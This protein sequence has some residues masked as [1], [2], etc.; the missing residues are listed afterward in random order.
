MSGNLVRFH[1]WYLSDSE[2]SE[3][4]LNQ[5]GKAEEGLTERLVSRMEDTFEPVQTS[6]NTWS[7]NLVSGKIDVIC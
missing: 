6:V 1:W 2:F 4:L 3:F 7:Q 5:M